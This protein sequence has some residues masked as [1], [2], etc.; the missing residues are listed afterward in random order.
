M[1]AK[2]NIKKSTGEEV[3]AGYWAVDPSGHLVLVPGKD[4]KEGWRPATYAD[5]RQKEAAAKAASEVAASP[6]AEA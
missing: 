4:L 5:L 1:I 3:I 2:T 6:A